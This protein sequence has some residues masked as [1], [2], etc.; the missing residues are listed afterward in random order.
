MP[1]EPVVLS[2]QSDGRAGRLDL[3][4]IRYLFDAPEPDPLNGRYHAR[5]GLDTLLQRLKRAPL[6]GGA[7]MALEI[8]LPADRM[9]ALDEAQVQRAL[10]GR[11][12]AMIGEEEE[13]MHLL[14]REMW[15]SLRVGGLFL[16]LCLLASALVDRMAGLPDFLRTILGESLVIAGW[17]GLWHPL[18]LVLYAWWPG[19][20]RKG[21]LGHLAAADIHLRAAG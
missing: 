9:Q 2:P 3:A 12:E 16:S 6:P 5:S 19:R 10:R 4:D 13:A 8:R 21:L 7:P 14:R 20:F 18:E 17:V 1:N 11:V 15:Q